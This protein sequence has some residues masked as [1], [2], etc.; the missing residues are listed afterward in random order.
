MTP[1]HTLGQTLNV[2]LVFHE[3]LRLLSRRRYL[4]APLQQESRKNERERQ[5]ESKMNQK[6]GKEFLRYFLC[7]VITF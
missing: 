3:L 1:Q 2:L 6:K 5:R 4:A 7:F